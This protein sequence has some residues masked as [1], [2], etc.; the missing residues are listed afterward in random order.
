MGLIR[1][2]R[3]FTK[4]GD[5]GNFENFRE[6]WEF[7]RILGILGIL[8]IFGNFRGFWE[9]LRTLDGKVC[10]LLLRKIADL[11]TEIR[12]CQRQMGF[13]AE[14]VTMNGFS[15]FNATFL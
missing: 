6:I 15:R 3:I 13:S 2:F 1:V 7:L 10:V 4:I 9:F 5:F 11:S 12:L 8:E 14:I